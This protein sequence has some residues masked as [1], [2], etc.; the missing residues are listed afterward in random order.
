[1]VQPLLIAILAA[2][3]GVISI[4]ASSLPPLPPV[5]VYTFD[6][7]D[8]S[9]VNIG[10]SWSGVHSVGKMNWPNVTSASAAK[11]H[12]LSSLVSPDEV[13]R[14]L[15]VVQSPQ[16]EFDVDLDSVDMS[17]T[18]EFYVEKSGNADGIK[19]INGKP[20]QDASVF[21]QRKPPREQLS[22]IMDP[23]VR[24][25]ILPFVNKEYNRACSQ[26]NSECTVCHSLV[27]R[28]SEDERLEHPAHFDLQALVTV[29]V[30]LSSYG[31]DFEGGLYVS[32][33]AGR[34]QSKYIAM[35]AG[36]AVAHQSNLLHGVRVERGAR[37]S[38]IMW[39]K[40]TKDC[41]AEE[42]R[43]L[44]WTTE[45]AERGDPV[46]QFIQGKR[47]SFLKNQLYW[48]NRSASSGFF[49]S[50]NEMGQ[51]YSDDSVGQKNI[52]EATQWFSKATQLAPDDPKAFYNLGRM[53]I[54][55]QNFAKAVKLFEKAATNGLALAAFNMAVAH[56][57]GQGAEKD[58]TAAALWMERASTGNSLMI[59]YQLWTEL[60]Q[61]KKALIALTRSGQTGYV[62][63][64]RALTAVALPLCDS[65]L[66]EASAEVAVGGDRKLSPEDEATLQKYRDKLKTDVKELLDINLSD[67]AALEI[68]M[69]NN[70]EIQCEAELK[71]KVIH[72]LQI[73]V[74][75]GC[76]DC[77]ND[78]KELERQS[79]P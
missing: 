36:D 49:E 73:A 21:E 60:G 57:K 28:Y 25:R 24:D 20:D 69:K 66:L 64:L 11:F 50:C 15:N 75:M 76:E 37:W 19:E 18:Y 79:R 17:S 45:D 34:R 55:E 77:R 35:Q 16:L 48:F 56:Y 59:A 65:L 78:L 70:S 7:T 26:S 41:S 9:T 67:K 30:S 51:F 39:F 31:T 44:N 27:R 62:P 61:P 12:L 33:G 47:T 5:R 43:L 22:A 29:V 68:C 6:E 71:K 23:I 54:E 52:Y 10:R 72:W 1:M 46:A 63:A 14:I 4:T 2:L 42:G 3:C 74:T 58:Y 32:T 53:A 38:W 13:S 8:N 40:D